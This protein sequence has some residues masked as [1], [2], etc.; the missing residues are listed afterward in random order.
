M[1]GMTLL[2]IKEGIILTEDIEE[3]FYVEK[4]K[5]YIIPLWKWLLTE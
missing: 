1:N 4:Y 3:E 2:N 5:I